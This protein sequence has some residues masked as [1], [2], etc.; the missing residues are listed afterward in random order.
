MSDEPE[1]A[2]P[3]TTPAETTLP[4]E[5][6]PETTQ[7]EA[8]R[9]D[10]NHPDSAHHD[11]SR[12]DGTYPEHTT[13]PFAETTDDGETEKEWWDDPRMPW[14]GKPGR[15]DMVCWIGIAVVG[16]YG[17][18]MMPLRAYLVVA[19]PRPAGGTHRV[20]VRTGRARGD[21]QPAVGAGSDPGHHQHRQVRLDLLPGRSAV[22]SRPDRA[23]GGPVQ[24]GRP[25]RRPGRAAGSP[26]GRTGGADHLPARSPSRQ[27]SSTRRW[28]WRA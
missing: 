5:S 26:L 24:A 28:R 12:S 3:D 2:H 6:R 23:D 27:P 16:V 19:Q 11:R 4:E 18:I 20:A 21:G 15:A 9:P 25:Q 8:T 7:P 10:Q 1:R 17:L 22:G 13:E 14:K